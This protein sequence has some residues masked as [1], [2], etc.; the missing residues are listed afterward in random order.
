MDRKLGAQAYAEKG[1]ATLTGWE[2]CPPTSPRLWILFAISDNP[3]KVSCYAFTMAEELESGRPIRQAEA[4][5]D[6][7][8]PAG[9]RMHISQS[10]MT[11]TEDWQARLVIIVAWP[12][13]VIWNR[14]H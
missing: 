5:L 12:V 9:K 6:N 1:L 14:A 8:E 10:G 7:V 13:I 11:Q 4:R 3:H 2:I